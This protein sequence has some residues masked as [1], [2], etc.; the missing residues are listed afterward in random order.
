LGIY[1]IFAGAGKPTS[2]SRALVDHVARH[3]ERP[4]EK[5]DSRGLVSA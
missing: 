4:A 1:A 5:P 2:P 3:F